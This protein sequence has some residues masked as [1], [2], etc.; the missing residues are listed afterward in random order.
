MFC[1]ITDKS[2]VMVFFYWLWLGVKGLL[3]RCQKL[4][5]ED[6]ILGLNCKHLMRLWEPSSLLQIV[7]SS[8]LAFNNISITNATAWHN[9]T[10]KNNIVNLSIKVTTKGGGFFW[11]FRWLFH[12]KIL[13]K[14]FQSIIV[15]N[16]S[17]KHNVIN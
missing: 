13:W 5:R 9:I 7:N 14:S 10:F 3:K 6:W 15:N 11:K 1:M 16:L 8:G 17:S 2:C 4:C 12:S